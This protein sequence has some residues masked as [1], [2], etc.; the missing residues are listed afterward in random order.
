MH[1][2]ESDSEFPELP[3]DNSEM[4]QVKRRIMDALDKE[5]TRMHGE[6][7][8][9]DVVNE[10]PDRY[11]REMEGVYGDYQERLRNRA[12]KEVVYLFHSEEERNDAMRKLDVVWGVNGNPRASELRRIFIE[13]SS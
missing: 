1:N 2:S 7:K 13:E 9:D 8:C 11:M 12:D 4:G 10:I 6:Q 5:Q 3:P